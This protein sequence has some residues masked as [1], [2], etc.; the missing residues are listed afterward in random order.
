MPWLTAASAFGLERI[1]YSSQR[2]YL[3]HLRTIAGNTA[4]FKASSDANSTKFMQQQLHHY[5]QMPV[6]QL[7]AKLLSQI[8]TI[9]HVQQ[10]IAIKLH[11]STARQF[12]R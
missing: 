4:T 12:K 3:H 8:T 1:C 5:Q 9:H 7:L 10:F 6:T 2:C 11:G